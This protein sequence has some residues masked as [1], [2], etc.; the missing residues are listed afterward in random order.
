MVVVFDLDDTLYPESAY[1]LSALQAVG[2]LGEA[3]LGMAGF[4][5]ELHRLFNSGHRT[6]LFQT[7]IASMNRP[8][9]TAEDLDLFL[10]T[11]R[12]HRP[13]CLEW[14]PDA[15]GLVK[16][17]YARYPLA[18][19]SDGYLPTQKLKAEALGVGEWF[20]PVI[21]TE[22]LGRKYWK[23][24]ARA[25]ELI[26]KTFPGESYVYIGD[27]RAKD[28]IAPRALGWNTVCVRRSDGI[29]R[30]ALAPVN[31]AAH[32]EVDDLSAAASI[33]A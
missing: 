23:P 30:D 9:P 5:M 18:I 1:A 11:Y 16:D 25:Y 13:D 7:A 22:E 17:L 4:A 27:N 8:A 19:I 14:Y 12:N 33:I 15:L 21:F 3:R 24:A 31:G 29:H 2:E 32:H 10:T 28:F 6:K 20:N 26:M